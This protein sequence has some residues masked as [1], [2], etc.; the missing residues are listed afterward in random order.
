MA[1]SVE[2]RVPL[3]DHK[4]VEY[5]LKLP[6]DQK[7]KYGWNRYIYRNALK[8]LIPDSTRLRRKKIGFTTPV[9]RWMRKR[10]DII[11]EIFNSK[12]FNDNEL[13]KSDM[14][15][16]EFKLWLDGKRNADGLIFWRVLNT[17]LWMKRFGIN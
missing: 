16:S 2:S 12:E 1:F 6:I 5:V 4:F 13:F 11:L 17:A 10:S 3:L 15:R 8:G 7:I 14:I 9:V